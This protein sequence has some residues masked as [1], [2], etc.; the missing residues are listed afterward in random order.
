MSA[1]ALTELFAS[2][3]ADD[4]QRTGDPGLS[5]LAQLLRLRPDLCVPPPPDLS[6]LA[7]R[8]LTRASV[9]RALDGL[10]LPHLQVLESMTALGLSTTE[11]I[12]TFLGVPEHQEI[13]DDVLQ[14][15]HDLALVWPTGPTGAWRTPA[16]VSAVVGNAA[17]GLGRPAVGLGGDPAAVPTTRGEVLEFIQDHPL[18][19]HDPGLVAALTD[20]LDTLQT[21]PATR[22]ADPPGPVL[23]V[24]LDT[25]LLRRAGAAQDGTEV[26]EHP[27]EAAL[28]WR[29]GTAGTTL[30]AGPPN[31]SGPTVLE[32][33]ARNAAL[34]AVT[35][36]LRECVAVLTSLEDGLPTLRS[37][38][39]GVREV[40][41]LAVRTGTE[42]A[43]AAWL[44][45]LLVAAGLVELDPDTSTWQ[46]SSAV[47][48]WRR[49]ERAPQWEVLVAGW[50]STGRAP[51]WGP[52]VSAAAPSATETGRLLAPDRTRPDAP[53]LRRRVLVTAAEA[54]EQ[55]PGIDL[56]TAVP[57]RLRWQHPRQHHR[58]ARFVPALLREAGLLGL[59]GAGALTELGRRVAGADLDGARVALE[60]L[61]PAPV[62]RFR[63]Q[64]D[65]TA[66][67][68]GYL[69]L[70]LAEPLSLMAEPEGEGPAQQYRFSDRSLHR[71]LDAGWTA[72]QILDFLAEHSEDRVP[73]AVEY[74]VRDVARRHGSL[75][76]GAAAAWLRAEDPDVLDAVLADPSLAQARLER[77]AP[78]VVV[79]GVGPRELQR[80]L[81]AS[82]H[83]AALAAVRPAVRP[84][85]P[86]TPEGPDGGPSPLADVSP[87]AAIGTE[88]ATT[89]FPAPVAAVR[90]APTEEEI[91]A[92]IERMRS[93]SATRSAASS[94][95][96][97]VAVLRQAARTREPVRLE[98]VTAQGERQTGVVVPLAV[99]GGRLRCQSTPGPSGF[100]ASAGAEMVLPLHRVVSA[101]T[102]PTDGH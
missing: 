97:A 31:I 1:P 28:A 14:H 73:Q 56:G 43:H 100:G 76:T 63:L 92:V 16:Q 41:R 47:P 51:L 57:V 71:A 7:A 66:V 96:Q 34:A 78:T 2:W 11:E 95:E 89:P 26:A 21:R 12:A 87:A 90:L 54:A 17:L 39:V 94:P 46:H 40:R 24:L 53:Q 9:S 32:P 74:L 15:L 64:G 30:S 50:L 80:L 19:H 88:A 5:R 52:P 81:Q 98:L 18:V 91:Q 35:D 69:D 29:D 82:G 23:R 4:P 38:G 65:L 68:P 48:H 93:G 3:L 36:L 27:L 58:T 37:G 59:S 22:V 79:A 25:G 42:P 77:L 60:R 83:H 45:E 102:V 10:D 70:R 44:V 86:P 61:L 6:A 55:Q 33:I 67:A 49:A 72:E 101:E 75:V 99:A 62:T 85:V 20:A 84:A 8:A 13:P